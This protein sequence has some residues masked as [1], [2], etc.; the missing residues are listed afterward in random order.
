ML[1]NYVISLT[2]A[3]QRRMHIMQEF[4]QK[5]ITFEFFD[6]IT[7]E[8]IDDLAIK[9]GLDITS[10]NLTK[11][12]LACLFSHI[13]LWQKAIDDDLEYIGIFEDDVYLAN[14]S[15]S[16]L[17]N[18]DWIPKDCHIIKVELF[19]KSIL[20]KGTKISAKDRFLIP[21]IDIHLGCAGYILSKD[22]SIS[23]LK[24]HQHYA[25]HNGMIAVDHLMFEHYIQCGEYH[26]YQ[27]N[28]CL[29]IQSD[30][31]TSQTVILS[32]LEQ[33]RRKRLD[34]TLRVDTYKINPY[35]K[36]W[37]EIKRPFLQFYRWMKK[38]I[39]HINKKRKTIYLTLD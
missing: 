26:S 36:I 20:S 23:L 39:T 15:Q 24:F 2:N 7:P 4:R 16:F 21:L 14:S 28:P 12:E 37:R 10:A 22:G 8:K 5:N 13:S 31:Q 32:Q 33:D 25:K 17:N 9:F 1:K 11:G 29:C 27:L 35:K 3:H 30:R 38:I 6:A 34:K 18:T 19:E